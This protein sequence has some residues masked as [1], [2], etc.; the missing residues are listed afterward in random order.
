MNFL[1]LCQRARRRCRVTGTGP[2]TVIGQNEEYARLVD[3]TNEAW[4]IIQRKR[5]DWKWM[6]NTATFPVVAGQAEYTL[7]QIESTG[8]GFS[9]FGNWAQDSFRNYPTGVTAQEMFMDQIGYENWRNTYLYSTNRTTTSRPIELAETPSHGLAL[10]PVPATGYTILGDY[11][12]V[13]SEMALDADE[14]ALDD[15]F[16]MAIVYGVMMLYG[17]AEAAP[18]VFDVGQMLYNQIMNEMERFYL[19]ELEDLEP[20]A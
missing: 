1:Q 4:M 7:A 10:G 20:L 18:E 6:R 12:K 2:T 19:P 16:H 9:N 11:Y 17:A 15:Q 14:P 13:A 5:P 8:S 3:Y